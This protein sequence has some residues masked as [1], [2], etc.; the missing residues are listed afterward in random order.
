MD[1]EIVSLRARNKANSL[2]SAIGVVVL[3]LGV[4]IALLGLEPAT[5]VAVFGHDVPAMSVADLRLT[6]A[7]TAR[8][9][10]LLTSL[11]GIAL[12]WWPFQ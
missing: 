5:T 1:L 7:G 3:F 12:A 2:I 6:S 11:V 4:Y 9:G 10:G 8:V